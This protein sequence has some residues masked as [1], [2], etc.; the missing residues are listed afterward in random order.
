M[1]AKLGDEPFYQNTFHA[2]EGVKPLALLATQISQSTAP[3]DEAEELGAG[4]VFR[5]LSLLCFKNV[6][7]A[8]A[9]T[10]CKVVAA[11]E[12]TLK[13][14]ISDKLCEWCIYALQNLV[15]YGLM[16]TREQVVSG[17]LLSI[18]KSKLGHKDNKVPQPLN[19]VHLPPTI[20]IQPDPHQI[21]PSHSLPPPPTP[22]GCKGRPSADG[23]RLLGRISGQ[24]EGNGGAHCRPCNSCG[25]K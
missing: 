3:L 22:G 10:K 20:R 9:V 24:D 23:T 15:V 6:E 5:A 13:G 8:K 16:E 14:Q 1:G 18:L 25:R 21:L 11:A 17:Q 7:L 19:P 4:Y 2:Q 12:A